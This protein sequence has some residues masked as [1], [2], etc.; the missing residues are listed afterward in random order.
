MK[1]RN[2]AKLVSSQSLGI[3]VVVLWASLFFFYV[4]PLLSGKKDEIWKSLLNSILNFCF[5]CSFIYKHELFNLKWNVPL[6]FLDVRWIS[7]INMRT[8]HNL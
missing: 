3:V 7:N 6:V 1:M 2:Y 8:V 5:L 4:F